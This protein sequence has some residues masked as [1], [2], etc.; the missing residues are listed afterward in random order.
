M[1]I[2]S[3]CKYNLITEKTWEAMK[4]NNAQIRNQDKNPN[5]T[6]V[7]YGSQTPLVLKGSFTADLIIG[8]ESQESVFMSY[9][10]EQEIFWVKSRLYNL[11]FSEWD[12][13]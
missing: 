5:K 11:E 4:N 10:E 6:F 12:C 13:K 7:A 9:P 3:G 8:K 1:L 2:D